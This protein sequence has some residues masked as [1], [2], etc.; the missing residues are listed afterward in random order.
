MLNVEVIPAVGFGHIL[1]SIL[2]VPLADSACISCR[3]ASGRAGVIA[4]RRGGEQA[5]H[6]QD[7]ATNILPMEV[8]AD[9]GLLYLDFAGAERFSRTDNSVIDRLVEVF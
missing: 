3:G 5:L 6:E 1:V 2:E 4:R 7:S 9:A 8:A